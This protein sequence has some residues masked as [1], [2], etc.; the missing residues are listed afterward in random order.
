[1]LMTTMFEVCIL[2]Y[3]YLRSSICR[4]ITILGNKVS[5]LTIKD[6]TRKCSL[7]STHVYSGRLTDKIPQGKLERSVQVLPCSIIY[8]N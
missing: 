3:D 2:L 1:M 5:S 4:V 8:T 6:V 7:P